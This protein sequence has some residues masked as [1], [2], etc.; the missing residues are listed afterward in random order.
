[1]WRYGDVEM[2]RYGDMREAKNDDASF[3]V[4]CRVVGRCW[5]RFF[6]PP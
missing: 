2:W 6:C 5:F 3:V 1:M 4:G